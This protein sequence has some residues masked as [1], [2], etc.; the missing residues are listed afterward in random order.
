M[1]PRKP[2]QNWAT[3]ETQILITQY[4]ALGLEGV[5]A[6]MPYRT[7]TAIRS[8]ITAMQEQGLVPYRLN[9]LQRKR[10]VTGKKGEDQYILRGKATPEELASL[11]L[12]TVFDLGS[13]NAMCEMSE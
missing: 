11:H 9:D 12:P 5:C 6:L 13:Q 4:A 8:K 3:H 1:K 7:K 10:A 2:R